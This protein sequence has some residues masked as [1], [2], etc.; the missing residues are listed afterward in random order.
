[1]SFVKRGHWKISLV[2]AL[3]Y[4]K[5]IGKSIKI[6]TLYT[7]VKFYKIFRNKIFQRLGYG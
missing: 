2:I 6:S 3:L 5:S 7:K 1:M 4:Y